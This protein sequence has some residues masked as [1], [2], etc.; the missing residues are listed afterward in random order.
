S[1]TS[2]FY[3]TDESFEGR[4]AFKEKR[5]PDFSRFLD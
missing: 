2:L 1:T 5:E 4:N 3:G